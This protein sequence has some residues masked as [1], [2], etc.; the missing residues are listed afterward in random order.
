MLSEAQIATIRAEAAKRGIP[1]AALL[2]AAER[3]ASGGAPGAGGGAEPPKI[4]QYHLP[5]MRVFEIRQLIGLTERIANDDLLCGEF[6]S[7]FGGAL[8]PSA[9]GTAT[10]TEEP[11]G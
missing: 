6:M 7:R 5:F 1:E 2:Q 9:G 3:L 8:A 4:Y 11:N 10:A